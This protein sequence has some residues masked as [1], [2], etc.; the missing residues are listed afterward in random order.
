VR[1]VAPHAYQPLTLA[2]RD[3]SSSALSNPVESEKE[4]HMLERGA[5]AAAFTCG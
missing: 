4:N 5:I 1:L 3:S 2:G